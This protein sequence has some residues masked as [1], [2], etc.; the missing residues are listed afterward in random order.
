MSRETLKNTLLEKVK[1][2]EKRQI[3]FI[4]DCIPRLLLSDNEEEKLEAENI[5]RKFIYLIDLKHFFEDDKY[6][7]FL[8]FSEK[9]PPG[10]AP[11]YPEGKTFWYIDDIDIEIFEEDPDFLIS[12]IINFMESNTQNRVWESLQPE[13]MRNVYIT[14][15]QRCIHERHKEKA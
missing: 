2:I 4:H 8:T 10:V 13:V 12:D 1:E 3:N 9:I 6:D 14:I 11:A 5:L 7:P 15:I